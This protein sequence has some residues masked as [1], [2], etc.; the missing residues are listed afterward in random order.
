[1]VGPKNAG[2][3]RA[4]YCGNKINVEYNI[5]VTKVLRAYMSLL[6]LYT[7]NAK[8]ATTSNFRCDV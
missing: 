5:I 4:L 8:L 1:M 7:I 6:L 3:D 2:V